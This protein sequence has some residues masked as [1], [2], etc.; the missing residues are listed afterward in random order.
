MTLVI[1]FLASQSHLIGIYLIL[2]KRGPALEDINVCLCV[3]VTQVSLI[4]TLGYRAQLGEYCHF[5]DCWASDSGPLL[6]NSDVASAASHE[7]DSISLSLMISVGS[8][9]ELLA[10]A[11][12]GHIALI[13]S[14]EELSMENGTSQTCWLVALR[15]SEPPFLLCKM[16]V[17]A[18]YCQE[19]CEV[20][21]HRAELTVTDH[22]W[23]AGHS[24]TVRVV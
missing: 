15:L 12:H 1:C 3:F 17:G 6:R 7:L 13:A 24:S 22:G 14:G 20:Q 2:P 21:L 8:S 18:L 9:L 23:C 16:E 10:H 5:S 4:V 19:S 11:F